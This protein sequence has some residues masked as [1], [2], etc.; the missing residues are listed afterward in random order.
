MP[1]AI[2]NPTLLAVLPYVE[3]CVSLDAIFGRSKWDLQFT[4]T[5]KEARTAPNAFSFRAV[6]CESCLSDGHCWKELLREIQRIM[7][8]PPALIVADRKADE[9]LWADVL[10]LSGRDLIAKSFDA[11]EVFRVV[12]VASA[13][14][15]SEKLMARPWKRSA[16]AEHRGV[17]ASPARATHRDSERLFGTIWRWR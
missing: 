17:L 8:D 10:N 9:I 12:I 13:I 16:S 11:R 6:I 5:F 4:G 2:G 14:S 7:A 15:E 3:D 1:E